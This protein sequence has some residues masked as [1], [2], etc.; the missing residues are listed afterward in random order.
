MLPNVAAMLP[1]PRVVYLIRTVLLAPALIAVSAHPYTIKLVHDLLDK[2]GV[3]RDDPGLK[4]AAMRAFCTHTCAGKVCA[5][6]IGRTSVYD[7]GLEMNPWAEDAF[8]TGNETIIPVKVA[9]EIG[10]WFLGVE[11]ADSNAFLT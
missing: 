2:R 5:S 8:H 11:Q 9:P 7:H 6:G 10:T 1:R 3:R 4:I